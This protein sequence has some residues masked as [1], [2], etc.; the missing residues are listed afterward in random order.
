MNKHVNGFQI[1][2][3]GEFLTRY[4]KKKKSD[5]LS[6]AHNAEEEFK[7]GYKKGNLRLATASKF[8]KLTQCGLDRY[9][10]SSHVVWAREGDSIIRLDDDL[11]WVDKFLEDESNETD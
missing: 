8:M 9:L 10:D 7:A 3:S 4:A 6:S 2:P 11:S 5:E 1:S